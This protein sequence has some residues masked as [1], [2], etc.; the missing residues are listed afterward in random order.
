VS[1]LAPTLRVMA[2][3]ASLSPSRAAD[4]LSCPLL[5]RFRTIDRL[6]QQPTPDAVRGTLVH[7]V[8]EDIF[9]LPAAER[10]PATAHAA[11]GPT[12]ERLQDADPALGAAVAAT[13]DLREWLQAG[14]DAL[15]RWFLL[16][17]PTRLEP[18]EREV[19]LE[20]VLEDGLTLRG[21]VDRIDVAPDGSV[22]VTDY[23]S[24]RA[25]RVGFEARALFQ[26]RFYA[27][28]LWRTRGVVP[29][30]LQLVYLGEGEG[31]RVCYE[32]DEQDLLA[33]ERKIRA[34]W[35]AVAASTETGEFQPSPGRICQWCSHQALCPAYGGTPPPLPRRE[36]PRKGRGWWRRLVGRLW[37]SGA[38]S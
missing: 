33:T 23:K 5:Y 35:A 13:V 20:C 38:A 24:G 26:L 29:R 14:H 28:V 27:L 34:I 37:R 8:L 25:P 9:D 32:P 6:P 21:V 2:A 4:F 19:L 16:E 22:R 3:T 12:W 10:T 17:D 11:L 31:E 36:D 18:A 30:L 1:D 15:D 7:Q